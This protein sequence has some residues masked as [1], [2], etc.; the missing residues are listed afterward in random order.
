M[1]TFRRLKE[2]EV[3]EGFILL[4]SGRKGDVKEEDML[5][6]AFYPYLFAHLATNKDLCLSFPS[7]ADAVDEYFSKFEQQRATREVEKA[8]Y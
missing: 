4:E 8:R 3:T 1:N 7:F 2:G 5:Y 6:S